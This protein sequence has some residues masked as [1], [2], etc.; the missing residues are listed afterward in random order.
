[1]RTGYHDKGALGAAQDVLGDSQNTGV[2]ALN[3][4]QVSERDPALM[5]SP[6][7]ELRGSRPQP[8]NR[9]ATAGEQRQKQ[10][11]AGTTFK[12]IGHQDVMQAGGSEAAAQMVIDRLQACWQHPECGVR[13]APTLQASDLLAQTRQ[14]VRSHD[15]S[16]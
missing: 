16:P 3:A 8:E 7:M 9:L 11:E 13:Q 4:D 1:M 15:C 14:R 6:G 10:G 5:Q 2:I 12:R